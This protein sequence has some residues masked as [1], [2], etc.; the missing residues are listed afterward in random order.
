MGVAVLMPTLPAVLMF[1]PVLEP[2]VSCKG[3]VALVKSLAVDPA[4]P[5]VALAVSMVSL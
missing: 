3:V 5:K 4:K 1:S 2:V